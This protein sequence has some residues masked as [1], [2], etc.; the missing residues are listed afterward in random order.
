MNDKRL[1]WPTALVILILTFDQCIKFFIKTHFYLGEEV[2]VAGNWFKLHFTENYGMAF[3]MEFGGEWGKIALTMFRI[4]AVGAIG[5]YVWQL[6][7]KK[8]HMG[9]ILSWSLIGAG[10]LGNIIDSVFYGIW[11]NE[12]TPFDKAGFLPPGGG[13]A[14]LFH[15]R[16]VDMFYFPVIRT[17]LP[18]WVPFWG[19]E[20]FEFFRPVF[21]VADAAISVGFIAIIL[22]Q[23]TFFAEHANEKQPAPVD[24]NETSVS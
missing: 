5:W 12:S 1:L 23:K 8:A 16:V 22:F 18:E 24:T 6:I 21:N 15:G 9:Y 11:F 14:T 10:A 3:G 2:N 20:F 4:L 19:G 17:T 13:Y 7:T